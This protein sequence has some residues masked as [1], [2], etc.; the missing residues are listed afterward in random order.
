MVRI[1]NIVRLLSKNLNEHKMT[2]KW[3]W[4]VKKIEAFPVNVN[5]AI[6]MALTN[7]WLMVQN[8][9]KLNSPFDKGTLRR[10]IS[11]DFSRIK[12]WMAVVWSPVAYARR[13]E[14]E[15][16]KNPDRK[17]Y[18]KRAYTENKMKIQDIIKKALDVKLK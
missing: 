17:F 12:Q 4:D 10:S 1:V 3:T 5:N 14:F 15:N 16:F 11:T 13:R 7:I 2:I 18:L 8:Q 9:A 6:E